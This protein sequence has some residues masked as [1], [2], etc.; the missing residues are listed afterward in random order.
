MHMLRERR[1]LDRMLQ[2]LRRLRLPGP[3]SVLGQVPSLRRNRMDATGRRYE[4]ES[5]GDA[6][7]GSGDRRVFRKSARAF[8]MRGVMPER[9][10]AIIDGHRR[11]VRLY[12]TRVL[13]LERQLREAGIEPMKWEQADRVEHELSMCRM[14]GRA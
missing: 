4:S 8:A 5:P 10:N 9:L 6:I 14:P 7:A 1:S 12:L 13:E 11:I 3:S 2:R